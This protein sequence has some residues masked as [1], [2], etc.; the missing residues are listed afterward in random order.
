MS[1]SPH[2]R[3][4]PCD[5]LAARTP[6]PPRRRSRVTSAC[7]THDKTTLCRERSSESCD[8]PTT[9]G[10]TSV[11]SSGSGGSASRAVGTP[12]SPLHSQEPSRPSTPRSPVAKV[13]AQR[14]PP[15]TVPLGTDAEAPQDGPHAAV[16]AGVG[17][18]WRLLPFEDAFPA[19]TVARQWPDTFA[20]WQPQAPKVT[21]RLGCPRPRLAAPLFQE[22]SLP[23]SPSL[24]SRPAVSCPRNESLHALI[25]STIAY[26]SKIS[27]SNRPH[28]HLS[29]HLHPP[30]MLCR[31]KQ[32]RSMWVLLFTLLLAPPRR[33]LLRPESATSCVRLP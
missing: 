15:P 14:D 29:N 28:P 3:T 8:R 18:W 7:Q 22:T 31:R 17:Q 19:G 24:S 1:E 10:A 12:L 16:G 13:A 4:D 25:A 33:D 27:M 32:R 26:Q 23:F 6:Y 21:R 20:P 2:Q 9:V 30:A 11:P 5:C